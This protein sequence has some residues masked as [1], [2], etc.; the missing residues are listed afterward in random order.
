M[1]KEGKMPIFEPDLLETFKEV[2]GKNLNLTSQIS[3]ALDKT[4]V[5]FLAL[6]TPTK[7]SGI[8]AGKSYDLSYTEKAVRNIA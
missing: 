4:D 7:T 8:N 6:P 5:I 1:C 2:Y 3:E